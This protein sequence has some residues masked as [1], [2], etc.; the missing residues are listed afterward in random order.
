MTVWNAFSWMKTYEFRLRFYWSL[1]TRMIPALVQIMA[2]C[3]PGDKSLSEPVMISLLTHKCI[4]CPQW[5]NSLWNSGFFGNLW[6]LN[7]TRSKLVI[8]T[9]FK[10]SWKCLRLHRKKRSLWHHDMETLS[11]LL[12]QLWGESTSYWWIPLIK[13]QWCGVLVFP[14]TSALRNYWIDNW[15]AVKL[16][17]FDAHCTSLRSCTSKPGRHCF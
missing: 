11:T 10:L 17:C 8:T 2:W 13:G 7:K 5:V 16:R 6:Y 1:F 9:W 3:W 14:S 15:E 12:A 4:T